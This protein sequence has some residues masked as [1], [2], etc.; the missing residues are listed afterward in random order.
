MYPYKKHFKCVWIFSIYLQ[1]SVYMRLFAMTEKKHSSQ[2]LNRTKFTEN[3]IAFA[4]FRLIFMSIDRV[5]QIVV[6]LLLLH[7]HARVTLSGFL[8]IPFL[9]NYTTF[10]RAELQCQFYCA[11]RR[12]HLNFRMFNLI[13]HRTL[14]PLQSKFAV[15]AYIISINDSNLEPAFI[16]RFFRGF[17]WL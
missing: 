3:K 12:I 6:L 10:S 17:F 2:L 15:V 14:L 9:Y 13:L 5:G 8:P 11:D 1:Y 16:E 7:S 4:R